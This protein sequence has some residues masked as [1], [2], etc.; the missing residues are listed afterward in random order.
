MNEPGLAD[1]TTMPL[2]LSSFCKRSN[3]GTNSSI[4]ALDN[5]LTLI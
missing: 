3:N 1:I 4:I 2:T 5:V